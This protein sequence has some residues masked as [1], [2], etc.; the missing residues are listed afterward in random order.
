MANDRGVHF[1]VDHLDNGVCVLEN[2]LFTLG[3]NDGKSIYLYIYIYLLLLLLL[4]FKYLLIIIVLTKMHTSL[5]SLQKPPFMKKG[6][7]LLYN[8]AM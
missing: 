8:A 6:Y 2:L 7:S 5:L 1:D 3:D 4:L